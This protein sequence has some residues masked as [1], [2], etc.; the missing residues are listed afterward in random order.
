M[1]SGTKDDDLGERARKLFRGRRY[2]EAAAAFKELLA[3][4]ESRADLHEGI[5]N[6]YFAAGQYDKAI[7]HFQRHSALDPKQGRSLVNLGAVYNRLEQYNKAVD[8]LRKG[9]MREKKSPFGYYNLGLAYRGLKQYAMAV[10]AYKESLRIDPAM[11]ETHQ[12]LA[13]VYVEMSNNQQ[14]IV[15]YR[16][17]LEIKPDF[18][19]AAAG[20]A[21]AEG[22]AADAKKAIKP[23]GRLVDEG[24]YKR[25]ADN[26]FAR[27]MSEG[28]RVQDRET[29]YTLGQQIETAAMT[30]LH[31]L[32][33]DFEPHLV[34][35]SRSVAQA[36]DAPLLVAK[37]YE[38]FLHSL[39]EI[40]RLRRELKRRVL[41]LRAHEEMIFAP[42]IVADR[43]QNRR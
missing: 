19:R 1:S 9:I 25:P 21:R 4:D 13:N 2:D 36:D 43:G 34:S 33:N 7:E 31:Q 6:A 38:Q 5:A 32:R 35:L 27:E 20:L 41:E 23:F 37:A 30:L 42:S 10:S 18:K 29:V 26:S 28:E 11:A 16:K 8:V 14:A 40:V 12:N 22:K 39:E 3:K 24:T 15:H 17:A